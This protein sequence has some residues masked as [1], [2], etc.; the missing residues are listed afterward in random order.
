MM[1]EE[2][3]KTKTCPIFSINPDGGSIYCIASGC[4][5]W[6]W[7]TVYT[8]AGDENKQEPSGHCGLING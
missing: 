7:E 3:A 6:V 8:Y 5:M 2:E 4:M 1:K